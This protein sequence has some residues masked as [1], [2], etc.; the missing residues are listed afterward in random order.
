MSKEV[1]FPELPGSW[2]GAG[3]VGSEGHREEGSV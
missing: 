1:A 2:R 3:S